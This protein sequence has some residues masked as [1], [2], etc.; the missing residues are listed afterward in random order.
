L[1]ALNKWRFLGAF[2]PMIKF[3]RVRTYKNV[4][5]TKLRFSHRSSFP[6]RPKP[7]KFHPFI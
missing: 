1:E 6:G 5:N 2:G 7:F 3:K 4:H